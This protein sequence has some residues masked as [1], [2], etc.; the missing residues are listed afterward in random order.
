MSINHKKTCKTL[1]YIEH[2]LM[3][4]SNVEIKDIYKFLL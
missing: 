2:L 1:R 4:T 3:L